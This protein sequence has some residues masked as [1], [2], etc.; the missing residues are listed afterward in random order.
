MTKTYIQKYNMATYYFK[1][2]DCTILHREDGPAVEHSDGH[3]EWYLNGKRHREDGA[4]IEYVTGTKYWYVN[5]KLHR[6]N[7]AAIEFADG[8]KIWFLNDKKYA[9]AEYYIAIGKK[10]LTLF[11]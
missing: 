3:K 11:I 6:E 1:D 4:A 7:G 8:I 2:E 9:E 10:N 5:G